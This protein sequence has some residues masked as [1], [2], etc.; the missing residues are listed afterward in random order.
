MTVITGG[1]YGLARR[2]APRSTSRAPGARRPAEE[3]ILQEVEKR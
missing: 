2:L 3:R 1:F